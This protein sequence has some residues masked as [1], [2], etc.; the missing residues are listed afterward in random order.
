MNGKGD[1]YRPVN[2]E[3]YDRNYERIFGGKMGLLRNGTRPGTE[4]V[5][6]CTS[7]NKIKGVLTFITDEKK[8]DVC[9]ECRRAAK[10]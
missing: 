1:T 3:Q 2:K 6:R 7:C 9:L 8:H 10:I 4:T 5:K